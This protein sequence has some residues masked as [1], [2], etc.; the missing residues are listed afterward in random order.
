M[1]RAAEEMEQILF[2]E[3]ELKAE[4]DHEKELQ[5][6]FLEIKADVAECKAKIQGLDFGQDNPNRDE[7]ES[8]KALNQ[9]GGVCGQAASRAQREGEGGPPHALVAPSQIKERR[10]TGPK[11][12]REWWA[13]WSQAQK[14]QNKVIH[15]S[16]LTI[17]LRSTK[18]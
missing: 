15:R 17:Y 6:E 5:R 14:T 11:E 4:A 10:L 1:Q 13:R 2:W 9:A 12:L 8:E 18:V 3:N 16:E 7:Q